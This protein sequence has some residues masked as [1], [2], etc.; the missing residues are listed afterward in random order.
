MSAMRCSSQRRIKRQIIVEETIKKTRRRRQARPDI[1]HIFF[2][3][4]TVKQETVITSALGVRGLG[5]IKTS[6][7]RNNKNH[8]VLYQIQSKNFFPSK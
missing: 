6:F 4:S 5:E 3:H 7:Q 8:K 2:P 1:K